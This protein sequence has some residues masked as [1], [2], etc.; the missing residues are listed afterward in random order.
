MSFICVVWGEFEL[1]SGGGGG[2]GGVLTS[3]FSGKCRWTER[4][5]V[6]NHVEHGEKDAEGVLS[7]WLQVVHS[8]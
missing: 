3:E 5:A 2:G 6:I 7:V 8:V 4:H 1:A